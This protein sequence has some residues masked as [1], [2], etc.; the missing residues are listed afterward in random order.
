M[1]DALYEWWKKKN[2]AYRR[3]HG[4]LAWGKKAPT[5]KGPQPRPQERLVHPW[6]GPTKIIDPMAH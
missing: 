5:P 3:Q 4:A 1:A 2:A 6:V